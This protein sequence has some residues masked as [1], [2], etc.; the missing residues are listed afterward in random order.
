MANKDSKVKEGVGEIIDWITL[1][2]TQDG[3]QYMWANG[4]FDTANPTKDCVASGTVL[5]MSDGKVDFLGGQN[6]FDAFSAGN[7]L[8]NGKNLTPYDE[9]I[10]QKWRGQVRQYTAG[11]KS[12]EEALKDFKQEVADELDIH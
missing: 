4:T 8:A 10:N 12:R 3:L 11:N 1:N 5:A 9:T 2:C 6:M 7:K